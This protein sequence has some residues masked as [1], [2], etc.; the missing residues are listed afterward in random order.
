MDRAGGEPIINIWGEKV[1]LGPVRRDMLPLYERW[2][3]D[4]EVTRGVGRVGP[5]T[6]EEEVEWYERASKQSSETVHFN[7]Y[8]LGPEGSPTYLRPIGTAGLHDINYRHSK[9][10]FGIMIGEKDAWGKGYG[11]EVAA[12]MLDYGFNV[13]GLHNISLKVFSFNQYAIRAYE[14]AGFKLAGNVRESHFLFGKRY[15]DIIMDCL[16]TEFEGKAI[17]RYMP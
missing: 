9:G 11:T 12:L 1:A 7:I 6:T 16:S 8:E 15:D 3:N 2:M 4:W 10:V 17:K 14:R 5:F 13:L